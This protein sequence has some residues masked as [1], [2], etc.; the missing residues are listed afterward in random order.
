MTT[1]S[2]SPLRTI[3]LLYDPNR[4]WDITGRLDL[5]YYPKGHVTFTVDDLVHDPKRSRWTFS[6]FNLLYVT[7]CHS[8]FFLNVTVTLLSV[9]PSLKPSKVTVT[10]TV[11]LALFLT[12]KVNMTLEV[13]LTKLINEEVTVILR[14]LWPGVWLQRSLLPLALFLTQVFDQ[15]EL[16]ICTC[17]I[18][19]HVH[20]S[21][22][23]VHAKFWEYIHFHYW[24]R[25]KTENFISYFPTRHAWL[26]CTPRTFHNII[27]I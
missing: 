24:G 3:D 13:A 26:S 17:I 22:Y 12:W 6:C 5:L 11:G 9:W 21:L 16:L 20:L 18:M 10:F 1:R 23:V 7:K 2:Q 15:V 27:Y 4:S 8:N 19:F 14:S 25:E